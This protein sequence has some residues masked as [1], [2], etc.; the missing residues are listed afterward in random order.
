[1]KSDLTELYS[2]CT[3]PL[4]CSSFQSVF[5]KRGH[6]GNQ[7]FVTSHGALTPH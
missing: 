5:A 2:N 6:S 4:V 7:P 3:V 1:M